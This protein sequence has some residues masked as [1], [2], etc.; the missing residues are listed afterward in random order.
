[1]K[2]VNKIV[3][4]KV[5]YECF[6]E[7]NQMQNSTEDALLIGKDTQVS[8]NCDITLFF[9]LFTSFS[10]LLFPFFRNALITFKETNILPYNLDEKLDTYIFTFFYY[11]CRISQLINCLFYI[12]FKS[13]LITLKK[14]WIK[15]KIQVL[16]F[17]CI[18]NTA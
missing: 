9:F 8:K 14:R 6:L 7:R 15:E 5:K 17:G 4:E 11:S 2:S 1:M 3:F 16:F 13:L 12:L 10:S 18:S